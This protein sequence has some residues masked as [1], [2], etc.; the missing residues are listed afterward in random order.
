MHSIEKCLWKHKDILRV[1]DHARIFSIECSEEKGI[2][3][4]ESCDDYFS[5]TLTREECLKLSEMFKDIA[6]CIDD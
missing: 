1:L 4:E 6:S 3:I 5:H 2:Y